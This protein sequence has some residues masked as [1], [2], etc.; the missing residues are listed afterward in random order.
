MLR[1]NGRGEGGEIALNHVI[2]LIYLVQLESRARFQQQD[3]IKKWEA[4]HGIMRGA[5]V[6][7]LQHAHKAQVAALQ[8]EITATKQVIRV[9]F[10]G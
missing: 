10:I 3:V 9:Q 2:V 5:S 4:D 7:E 1:S 8:A 6:L